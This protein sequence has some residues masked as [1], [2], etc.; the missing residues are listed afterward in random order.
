MAFKR[1]TQVCPFCG[2]LP[3]DIMEYVIRTPHGSIHRVT[4]P[5]CGAMGPR[6]DDCKVAI[7]LWELRKPRIG[8]NDEENKTARP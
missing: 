7:H 8:R 1:L 6:A 3:S 2:F 5:A 4:C